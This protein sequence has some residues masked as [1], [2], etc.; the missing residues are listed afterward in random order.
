MKRILAI[1]LCAALLLLLTGCG[2]A[3]K[4]DIA[5]TTLPV[6]EFTQA[7]AGGSG[8]ILLLRAVSTPDI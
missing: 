8:S 3:D 5:A 1:L 4:A 2:T 7:P 6:A